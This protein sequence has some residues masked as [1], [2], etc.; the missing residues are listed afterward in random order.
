MAES[1][2]VHDTAQVPGKSD[3]AISVAEA[4]A[5]VGMTAAALRTWHRRYGLAPSVRTTGGHRRYNADDLAR[6][7]LAGRLVEDGVPAREAVAACLALAPEQLDVPP[8][9]SAD[10]GAG[11]PGGGRVVALPGG[12]EIQRGIGRAALALDGAA[13][14]RTVS[15]LMAQ[16]GV[17]RTWTDVLVPVLTALGDRWARTR[18][19]VEVEHVTADAIALA[20]ES[21]GTAVP[22][23]NRPVLLACM[24]EEQ[25]ALPLLAL[26]A[27]LRDEQIP[28]TLLGSRVPMTALQDAVTRLR[29]RRLVLWAQL[30]ELADDTVVE[31]LPALRP[32]PH[33]VLAGPGWAGREIPG[34]DRPASLEEAVRQISETL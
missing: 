8:E 18:R 23:K 2:I 12:S 11:R 4:A 22:A 30:P 21:H 32:R 16:H 1:A 33:V 34:T 31:Q 7:R 26:Q 27:A 19:G 17:I 10:G 3:V 24:P 9:P 14:T 29:P 6:I 5:R 13:I 15:D 28:V 25:H 20:L